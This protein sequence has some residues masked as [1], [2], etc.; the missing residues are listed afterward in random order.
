MNYFYDICLGVSMMEL[1]QHFRKEEEAFIDQILSWKE[2][3][4]RT[5]QPKLTNFLDPRE[6]QLVTMLIST[7][8]SDVNLLFNGGHQFAERK[9]A[10]IAPLYE[11]IQAVDTGLTLLEGHFPDKFIH[12]SHRDVMGA[13]LSL[14]LKRQILGDIVVDNGLVQLVVAS[15]IA[16]YVKSHLTKIKHASVKLEERPVNEWN[17]R[18]PIWLEQETTVSSLRLDVVVKEAYRL[19]R[20]E[21]TE[22]IKKLLVKVNYKLVDDVSFTLQAGDI[23]SLRGKGR[24]KLVHVR[25]RSK[26]D[27]QKITLARLK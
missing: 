26:K 7:K 25:G 15:E 10:V 3:V 27:K 4:E 8:D 18:E 1:Y 24:S 23:L 11:D 12:L 16:L 20:K 6:Q 13:C 5:Y 22:Y 21:A 19:S 9:R 17:I 2:Q 14:G